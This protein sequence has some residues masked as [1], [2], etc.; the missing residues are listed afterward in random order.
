MKVK[1]VRFRG[2]IFTV[3][4]IFS[5]IV[6]GVAISILLYT[7]FVAPFTYQAPQSQALSLIQLMQETPVG[8]IVQ[9]GLLSQYAIVPNG[10]GVVSFKGYNVSITASILQTIAELYLNSRGTYGD[11]LAYIVNPVYTYGIFINSSYAPSLHV[12]SF[13]GGAAVYAVNTPTV[14]YSYTISQWIYLYAPTGPYNSPTYSTSIPTI[15]IYNALANGGIGGGQNLDFGGGFAG[16]TFSQFVWEENGQFCFTPANSI[17]PNTWYDVAVSVQSYSNVIIY[18]NGVGQAVCSLTAN[19]PPLSSMV[20]PSIAIGA[21]PVGT[22]SLFYGKIANVQ[23]YNQ[24]LSG[25][26]VARLYNGGMAGFPLQNSSLIGW[27]PLLGDSYSY[28]S[29]TNTFAYNV[30]Y[31]STS[32]LPQSFKSAYIVSK[33]TLPMLLNVSSNS[34]LYNTSVVIWR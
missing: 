3:D 17:L 23:L 6:A 32:Y 7:Y 21:N 20:I 14:G 30:I 27:W 33:A 12:A 2:F 18:V 24:T 19:A 31:N 28:M 26:T 13:N 15:D 9:Q 29:N 34:M 5:L 22:I 8:Q 25:Y 11:I 4:A 1:N 10:R 16:G